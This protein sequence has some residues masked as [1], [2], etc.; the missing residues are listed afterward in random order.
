M[1]VLIRQ[2]GILIRYFEVFSA[3]S[4]CIF[5]K[6]IVMKQIMNWLINDHVAV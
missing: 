4:K 2:T 5:R 6:F 1:M 3:R